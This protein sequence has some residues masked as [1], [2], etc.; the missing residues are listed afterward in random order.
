MSLRRRAHGIAVALLLAT[1]ACAAALAQPV[2][3]PAGSAFGLAPPPGYVA[4]PGATGFANP[5][6]PGAS[7]VLS[8]MP[9]GAYAQIERGMTAEALARSG[10]ELLARE[11]FATPVGTGL[12]ITGTQRAGE[13]VLAKWMLVVPAKAG[14]ANATALIVVTTPAPADP[15]T[16]AAMRAAFATLAFTPLSLAEKIAALPFRLTEGPTLKVGHTLSGSSAVLT[17]GG[18]QGSP[19][20]PLLAV[21]FAPGDAIPPGER[22]TAALVLSR[23]LGGLSEVRRTQPAESGDVM[24]I[25]G[26]GRTRDG[27]AKRFAQWVVFLPD[28]HLRILAMADEDSFGPLA[29]EFESIASSVARR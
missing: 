26:T 22:A 1:A 17:P 2:I 24:R 11:S 19:G 21:A 20:S 28:G 10:I 5:A 9:A 25:D 6:Q 16:D 13:R 12:L 14:E 23:Q 18:R 4:D 15:A 8:E 3:T 29:A 7:I 27:T